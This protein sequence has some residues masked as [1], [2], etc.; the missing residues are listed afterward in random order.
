MLKEFKEFAVKG[1]MI[2]LAVGVVVGGAFGKI[3]TSLVTDI[4]TPLVGL[5]LGNDDLSNLFLALGEGSFNTVTQA[6]DAGVATLNYGLFLKNI[7]DFL[8]IAFAIFIVIKQLNRFKRKEVEE[9]V[10]VTTKTCD[11]CYSEIHIDAKRCPNC[12]SQLME[13]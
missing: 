8:I 2:D 4:I 12:T 1:N 3:V 9:E 6:N 11:Y 13:Q 10:A 5:L 7:I